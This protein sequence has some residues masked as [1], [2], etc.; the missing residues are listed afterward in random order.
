MFDQMTPQRPDSCIS[1][2]RFD[3]WQA[4]ELEPHKSREL[5]EHLS[6]CARC[7]A[8]EA[9]LVNFRARFDRLRK[10]APGPRRILIALSA[11]FAISVAAG[12]VLALMP[13][14]PS[15][16]RVKGGEAIG[17]FRKRGDAVQRGS[18]AQP[19]RPGDKLRFVYTSP[20]PRYLA[21][22]GLDGAKRVSVYYPA[23]ERAQ[24][25]E[26]GT[27]VALPFAIEL[28]GTAGEEHVWAVFCDAAIELAPLRAQIARQNT[29]EPP[30][31]CVVDRLVL[32]KEPAP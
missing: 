32:S 6:Q 13:S 8:R 5:R 29:F 2:L 31:G 26:P 25:I 23:G 27:D 3:A 10:P 9:A 21:I 7:R 16:E 28:D 15:A 4:G 1:D 20:Q 11:S 17:Y 24:A 14:A 30:A 18:R 22:L 19:V 12:L